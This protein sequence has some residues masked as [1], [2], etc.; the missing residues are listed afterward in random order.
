MKA[1]LVTT[2]RTLARHWP[3]MLAWY[4]GGVAVHYAVV[5]LAG[6]VGA[7]SATVGFLILPIA[8]LARLISYVAM[9]LVLRD[10]LRELNAIAPQPESAAERRTTFLT[11]LLAGILPFFAVYWGQGL[12]R[13]DVVA[14]SARA[15]RERT[16]MIFQ[17]ALTP[18]GAPTPGGTLDTTG[19]VLDSTDSVL[20][21]PLNIWTAGIIVVAFAARWA[22]TKWQQRIPGWVSPLAVYLEVV[23]VFFSVIVI[24]DITDRV[25]AWV[26]ARAAVAWWEQVRDG[27]LDAV[28]PL[29]WAWDGIG[30]L[31]SEAGPVL[32]APLAWLTVGG[33]VYGQ[34][35]VAEK[36]RIQN[37]LLTN[38]REHAAVIPN[39]LLRRLKDL[40][41][42]LGSRFVPI[43]RALLLMW[44]AGPVLVASYALLHVA[45]KTAETWLQYGAVRAIGPHD[46]VFWGIAL[47][48]VSLVPLLLTEPTRIA[49]IAGAYDA[50][51]GT[52]RTRQQKR[53]EAGIV[54]QDEAD[55]RAVADAAGVLPDAVLQ[56]GRKPQ[57]TGGQGSI[58]NLTNRPSPDGAI[59]SQN[60]P[61]TSSGT[62]K[63][64][65]SE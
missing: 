11:A 36:L 61:S 25:K 32:L 28:A 20:N 16:D 39:P 54:M 26:D 13:D 8:I 31:L 10:G 9:F 43:G 33:V 58:E 29:R 45:V 21:L 3:A 5:Q 65:V 4:L 57:T 6:V 40:G 41:D 30:W 55:V 60:G 46:L 23:W 15:L 50:T 44:R 59:S 1:I 52:L 63:P 24:G 14:Y 49:V 17:T 2:G 62:M 27:A 53:V 12:L 18:D 38:L 34:A 37:E 51:L 42:E 56:A 48:L 64:A 35:I 22:W 7:H 47:P 19:G